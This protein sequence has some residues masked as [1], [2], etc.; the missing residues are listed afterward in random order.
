MRLKSELPTNLYLI[1]YPV[2]FFQR[3]IEHD[4]RDR[5]ESDRHTA[6]LCTA[7]YN[8]DSSRKVEK[9]SFFRTGWNYRQFAKKSANR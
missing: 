2:R 4:T 3:A 6:R 5:F 7:M 8:K 9:D 1:D